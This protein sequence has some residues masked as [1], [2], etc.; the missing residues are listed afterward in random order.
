MQNITFEVSWHKYAKCNNDVASLEVWNTRTFVTL[1][2]C[3]SDAL[4][5][6]KYVKYIIFSVDW[7]FCSGT[8][9]EEAHAHMIFKALFLV[10][11][12]EITCW[13]C[14]LYQHVLAFYRI[15]ILEI[16]PV[17][18]RRMHVDVMPQQLLRWLRLHLL[19]C[20]VVFSLVSLISCLVCNVE[21]V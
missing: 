7:A 13:E 10:P 4:E 12:S 17:S 16:N 1:S 18:C 5:R 8:Y 14:L 11:A 19:V 15:V 3:W 21:D 20:S 6:K 9:A 2:K